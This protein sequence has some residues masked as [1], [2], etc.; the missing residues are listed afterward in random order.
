[1]FQLDRVRQFSWYND[2]DSPKHR[3]RLH[4]EVAHKPVSDIWSDP[5][6]VMEYDLMKDPLWYQLDRLVE[7]YSWEQEEIDD[8]EGCVPAVETVTDYGWDVST[9]HSWDTFGDEDE[10]ACWDDLTDSEQ[11]GGWYEDCANS[12]TWVDWVDGDLRTAV[13]SEVQ[14]D[15]CQPETDD[16]V[17]VASDETSS[18]PS[19]NQD[20]SQVATAG[21]STDVPDV[22]IVQASHAQH[23][24]Q[25]GTTLGAAGETCPVGTVVIR[26][27]VG[28]GDNS[29]RT[30]TVLKAQATG[31]AII[32]R[33]SGELNSGEIRLLPSLF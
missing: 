31:W 12:P 17:T 4:Q 22:L 2:F 20:V 26:Y 18:A 7:R 3:I 6:T 25:Q 14:S 28:A 11:F 21:A 16:S 15:Q 32:T 10:T 13:D 1:L 8:S 5:K 9:N 24:P 27:E 29:N 33:V 23:V 30:I 19:D